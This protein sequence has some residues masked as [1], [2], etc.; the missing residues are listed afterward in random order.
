MTE[1]REEARHLAIKV[2]GRNVERKNHE[3][4]MFEEAMAQ[5]AAF[6]DMAAVVV[7]DS[8]CD[9]RWH[10]G[11]SGIVASRILEKMHKPVA[12]ITGGKGSVRAPA[13]Y[14]VH[15]AL[16]SSSAALGRF[17]G[18][19]AAGGFSVLEGK[20][21]EFTELFNA[22]CL[23]QRLQGDVTNVIEFDGWLEPKEIKMP[24][25]EK[26]SSL[27]PFGEGNP[28]PVFGLKGVHF[29]DIK[30]IGAEGKHLSLT[31]VNRD[32]PRAVW[33]GRGEKTEELRK[34]S[35]ASYDILFTV[36]ATYR[37]GE[38][39]LELRIVDIAANKM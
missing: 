7:S 13:G 8:K 1:D 18:H 33:W 4:R 34:H 26:I 10:S 37:Y 30:P 29:S 20:L 21:A 11:V 27:S 16:V 14:N 35:S 19:Q 39:A 24:L 5:A 17:G 32:I 6:E 12:V 28:E 9:S 2:D 31:F 23:S 38:R 25:F 15:S 36:V 22:A 3:S